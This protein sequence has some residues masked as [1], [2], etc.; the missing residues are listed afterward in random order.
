M[1]GMQMGAPAGG[2]AIG[3]AMLIL[4]ALVTIGSFALAIKFTLWP[5]ETE[6]DHPKYLILRDDR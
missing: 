2:D 1:N 3:V 6:A 5:G 4:G